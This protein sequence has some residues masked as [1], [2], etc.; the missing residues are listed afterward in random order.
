MQKIIFILLALFLFVGAPIGNSVAQVTVS[1]NAPIPPPLVFPAPPDI[2]VVP[3]GNEHVYMVPET[4]G[5]YFHHGHWYRFHEGYWYRSMAYDGQ[6]APLE[7]R[8]VPPVITRVPPEYPHYLPRDYHRIHHNDFHGH[9]RTWDRDRH[10]HHQSW[11]KREARADVRRERIHRIEKEH[12]R[13]HHPEAHHVQ[14][15]KDIHKNDVKHDVHG[16][17]GPSE[18]HVVNPN[19]HKP[20]V[21]NKPPQKTVVTNK[22]PQKTVVSNKPKTVVNKPPKTVVNAKPPKKVEHHDQNK[23]H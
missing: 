21:T 12:P 22:P 18:K 10:W 15:H 17:T 2:V 8:F 23:Q 6:W 14:P 20:V 7:P 9:W 11:Y 3:S 16:K 19:N 13:P 5:V 4:T 1:V